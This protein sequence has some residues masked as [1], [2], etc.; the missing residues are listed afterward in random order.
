[1]F[2]IGTVVLAIAFAAHIGHA[3]LLANGRRLVGAVGRVGAVTASAMQPAWAGVASGSFIESRSATEAAGPAPFATPSPLSRP[4]RW[5]A[6]G[7]FVTLAASMLLRAAIV[8]RGPWGNLFE[9]SVAF[10][11]SIL[12][13]Y[14]VLS[15]R[16]PIRSIGFIPTGVALALAVYASSLPSDVKP[17]VPALQNAPLL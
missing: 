7:A 8:G 3:V 13:G 16:Y 12:G 1:L 5:L 10:A 15:R 2:T 14:L 11:V 17:L 4:A 9:F 6:I